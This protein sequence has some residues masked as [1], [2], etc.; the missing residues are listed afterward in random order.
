MGPGF[1]VIAIMGCADGSAACT[2]VATLSPRY[3]SH[4]Q[5][6]ANTGAALAANTE[7]D[8]PTLVAECRPGRSGAA[9]THGPAEE[10]AG[11]SRHG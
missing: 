11:D 5:C 6:A 10:P 8:F 7:F 4:A 3:A 9:Q 2:P 1:F